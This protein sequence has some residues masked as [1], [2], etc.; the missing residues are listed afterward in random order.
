MR[1]IYGTGLGSHLGYRTQFHLEVLFILGTTQHLKCSC[2]VRIEVEI[3][4]KRGDLVDW[5]RP[6]WLFRDEF[7]D[8]KASRMLCNP[9][10]S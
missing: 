8:V 9:I 4:I 1:V 5:L 7:Q 3:N 6:S 2:S 10:L